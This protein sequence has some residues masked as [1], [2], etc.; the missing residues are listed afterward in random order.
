MPNLDLEFSKVASSI[1]YILGGIGVT[2]QYTLISVGLGIIAGA[3]LGLIK[4]SRY[5]TLKILAAFY[6]SIF[7]GTPLLVQLSLI[8]YAL[9]QL[10]G[11]HLTPFTA[12][13]LSFSLN[14]TA[15]VSE[16]I[17][18]GLQNMDTGQ[19]ECAHLLGISR[20]RIAKDIVLPQVFR[21]ILPSLVNEVID[22]LKESALVSTIGE[23]DLL[24]R[25]T[26]VAS[27]HYLYFEPLII[28]AV[29]YYS[30]VVLLSFA[31]KKLENTWNL[32]CSQS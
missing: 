22:L 15:Y 16:I 26:I 7:R 9:P 18:G 11:I 13:I 21:K 14:S 30:L 2:L 17:K 6:T 27:E 8:Y 4:A 28:V 23:A 31:A 24:R 12:G 25:A 29:V 19:I 1:P 10:T 20:Y 32:R 5:K 3:G